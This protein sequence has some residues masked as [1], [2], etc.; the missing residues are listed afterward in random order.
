MIQEESKKVTGVDVLAAI[1]EDVALSPSLL[2]L[3]E[4]RAEYEA[5]FGDRTW[6]CPSTRCI[7]RL[8]TLLR[9]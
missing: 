2:D 5:L 6:G 1:L 9:V 8:R 4:Q 3:G 7:S